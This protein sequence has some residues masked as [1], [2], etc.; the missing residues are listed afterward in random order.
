MNDSSIIDLAE[1]KKNELGEYSVDDILDDVRGKLKDA[2]VIGWSN[3]DEFVLTCNPMVMS[4]LVY[5]LEL[6][7]NTLIKTAQHEH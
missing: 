1:Y 4:E 5:L 2:I 3:E 7:K 6:A